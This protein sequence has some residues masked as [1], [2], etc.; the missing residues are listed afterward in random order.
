[1]RAKPFGHGFAGQANVRCINWNI[2]SLTVIDTDEAFG[3]LTI[4][5]E[6]S[7]EE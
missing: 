4:G 1:L 7:N 2:D 6:V 3:S 5:Y